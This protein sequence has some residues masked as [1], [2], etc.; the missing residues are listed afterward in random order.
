[1]EYYRS[2]AARLG[3]LGQFELLPHSNQR[4]Q[5]NPVP[6]LLNVNGA[7]VLS[8]LLYLGLALRDFRSEMGR[9][10][11]FQDLV[12]P[13]EARYRGALF[14]IEV[15][16]ELARGGLKPTYGTTSPDF[17]TK[18]PALGIE[19]TMREVPVPRAVAER[20]TLTL[21]FLNP[22]IANRNAF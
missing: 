6:I 14:E 15:G 12:C 4:L 10:K 5:Y 22:L 3:S 21:A 16:S 9:T 1:M 18:N 7:G 8:Q 13:D 2:T 19:A 20:L 11:A 17:I